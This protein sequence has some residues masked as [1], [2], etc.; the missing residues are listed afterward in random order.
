[1]QL[2][3]PIEID[4]LQQDLQYL[5]EAMQWTQDFVAKPHSELGRP[6][7]VCPFVPH[8]IR[9]NSMQLAVIRAKNVEPE[10]FAEIVA[11]YR[12]IFLETEPLSGV[13][14]IRKTLLLVVPDIDIADAHKVI[15]GTQ[16]RLKSFFV[17]SGLMLGEFHKH[18][19]VPGAHNS[20]FRPFQSSIPMFAIRY[21][22]ESDV[23]FLMDEDPDLR[24]KYLQ[25][26]LHHM[27]FVYSQQ[28]KQRIKDESRIRKAEEGL[29]LAKQEIA[30]EKM[31]HSIHA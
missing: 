31:L 15:D 17:E 13:D 28:F 26:Y 8:S 5:V 19:Q 9:A 6:G 4:Q 21:M 2:Y 10:K 30:K 11:C 16:K 20:N 3:T 14:A 29:E 27:E 24:I 12:D 1:M 25:A 22:F 7:P 18:N 23:V